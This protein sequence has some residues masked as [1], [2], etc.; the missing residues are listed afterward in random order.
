[1]IKIL[2]TWHA[3]EKLT[4]RKITKQMVTATINTPSKLIS[5]AEKFYAFRKF[6]RKY[7]KVIFV[8]GESEVKI[9]TQHFIDFLP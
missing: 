1:M 7:L 9:I 5:D 4:E 6:G 8:R 2:F 3:L